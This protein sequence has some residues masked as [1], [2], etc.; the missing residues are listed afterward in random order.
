MD[1]PWPK[2]GDRLF[3]PGAQNTLWTWKD[4]GSIAGGYKNAGDVLIEW[5]ATHERNDS[6]VLPLLFCYRQYIELRLK[7]I[8]EKVN[9][10]EEEDDSYERVH[11]L[12][13]LWAIVKSRARDGIDDHE[14]ETLKTVEAC[15]MEFHEADRR[16]VGF[17]Y[18]EAL[19][20]HNLD[21]A[22]LEMVMRRISTFLD[23]LADVWDA[24]ILDKS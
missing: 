4:I 3:L 18:P 22:N 15:I 23:S 2:R 20:F 12:K 19:P 13:K 21:V 8:V 16:G 1:I 17:R 14:Y 11:D 9:I 10:F 5:L 24:G 7:D 6:L